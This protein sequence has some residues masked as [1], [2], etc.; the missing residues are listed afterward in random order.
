MDNKI[1]KLT[2]NFSY[3]CYGMQNELS[4][5]YMSFTRDKVRYVRKSLDKAIMSN[6]TIDIQYNPNISLE[7]FEAK[8]F[9]YP[10]DFNQLCFLAEMLMSG[11]DFICDA[12]EASVDIEYIDGTKKTIDRVGSIIIN[13]A[14]PYG[15]MIGIAGKYI[16][17]VIRKLDT[18]DEKED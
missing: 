3:G 11:N 13:E 15:E 5:D 2:I 16:P 18:D 14:S 4:R 6:P 7:T 10:K 9:D 1:K 12:I 8:L 17:E